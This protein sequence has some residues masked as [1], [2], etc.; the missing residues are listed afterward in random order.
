MTAVTVRIPSPLRQ[1]TDG[2]ADVVVEGSD[3]AAALRTLGERY[4][5]LLERAP[6]GSCK[7]KEVTA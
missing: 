1:L 4:A 2:A 6:A 5:G 3:V 7:N